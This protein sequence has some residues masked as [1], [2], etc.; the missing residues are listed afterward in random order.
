MVKTLPEITKKYYQRLTRHRSCNGNPAASQMKTDR[1]LSTGQ[2]LVRETLRSLAIKVS[3]ATVMGIVLFGSNL[4]AQPGTD[5]TLTRSFQV[6]HRGEQSRFTLFHSDGWTEVVDKDETSTLLMHA[7][8]LDVLA[9]GARNATASTL[10]IQTEKRLSEDE[11]ISRLQA[12]ASAGENATY[13]S[14]DGWPAFERYEEMLPDK[15]G[16]EDRASGQIPVLRRITIAI[17]AGSYIIRFEGKNLAPA[18]SSKD[19]EGDDPYAEMRTM[20]QNV[21]FKNH[22]NPASTELL[23]EEL[24]EQAQLMRSR[25]LEE[26][27][28]QSHAA[29]PQHAP[30]L[31]GELSDLGLV[32]NTENFSEIEVVAS[33]DGQNIIV[34]TNSRRYSVSNDGGQTFTQDSISVL[35]GDVAYGA[36]GD[37]SLAYGQSGDFYF[38]FIAYPN[39]AGGAGNGTAGCTTG[40][41]RSTND[42]QDFSHRGHATFCVFNDPDGGGP[43]T[44][45]FPDQE[46]IAADRANP[47]GTGQDQVYSAWRNFTPA[48]QNL[49]CRSFGS[50]S[51]QSMLTCSTDGGQTFGI[52]RNLV[53]DFGRVTVGQDGFVYVVTRSFG[54]DPDTLDIDKYSSCQNGLVQQAGFPNTVFNASSTIDCPVPGLDRCNDGNDLRSVSVT[55][56]DLDPS[57]IFVSFA[58][59]TTTGTDAGATPSDQI[60][61]NDDIRIADSTNG[62]LNWSA[63]I[64]LN[65]GFTARR[66][67]PWPCAVG[68]TAYVGWYDRR[69][70]NATENSFTDY[71]L[72]SA[73]RSGGSLVAGAEFRVSPDSDSNCDAGWGNSAPR[74]TNDSESCTDQPQQAGFCSGAGTRCDF[75]D[76]N[77]PGGETCDTGGGAPK[78]GDYSGIACAAGRVY[79]AY[80][81]ATPPGG[82]QTTDIDSFLKT[83]LVCCVPQIQV[84]GAVNFGEACGLEGKTETLQ[85]CNT[86][87]ENL[88]VDSITSSD[89]Q[90]A[91]TT[92]SSGYPV[93]ISAGAC[94]PFEVTYDPDGIGDDSGVLTIINNDPVN[95]ALEVPVTGT[96]GEASINTFIV[97]SG[98]FGNVCT[99]DIHDLNLTIQS[100]GSCDL[101]IDSVSLSGTDAADFELPD[102]S[103]AGTIIE[104]GNS[105]LVPV[106]FAPDNFTDPNPRTASVDVASST[107]DGDSLPLDQTPIEGTVPPPDI[108]LAIANMGNF[109]NVC[110]GDFADLDLTLFNQGMCD[111]EISNIELVPPGGSF[112]LP[113]DLDLPLTLSPDADFT[114]PVRYAPDMCDDDP[115]N[116]QIKITSD[117][118]DEGMKF[119]DIS[120]TSPCPNLVI[121][122]SGLTGD[123]AFPATVTDLDGSLGCY[124]EKITVLRNNS[125]CL[126]TITSITASAVDEFTVQTPSEFPVFLPGGE[127]TLEVTVRFTPQSLGDPL[128]PDEFTG[129]L[130]IVS[131]DPDGDGLAGLC[132]EGVAQS[133]VRVLATDISSGFP[134]VVDEVDNIT[135]RSKGKKT[136]SPI[137]LKFTDVTPQSVDI[138]ENTVTW[139]VDQETLPSAQTE[140]NNPKSSYQVSAKEGNLQ[141]AQNFNLGQCNFLEFQLQLQ[142]SDS[143]ICLLLPKGASC[144][145]AGECCSGKCKGPNGN[146]TCK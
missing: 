1:D 99:D 117:D 92:P 26:P 33:P 130:T 71:Y 4:A 80:A 113:S 19:P 56:D 108:N 45:C 55:V 68:G 48:G 59:H 43:L 8:E 72:G 78:Y 143:E 2:V 75:S 28:S 87:V 134:L 73:K 124:S 69:G 109:G 79:A 122:P 137:N 111:L 20:A 129:V 41:T 22:G 6:Q 144:T 12:L 107:Q 39:G 37:P 38:A 83:D 70:A 98:D 54:G 46:H 125:M 128:A 13:F 97:D 10:L 66:Y 21:L 123:F 32:I 29:P 88:E 40:I 103:L 23:L 135:I 131:D 63:P 60:V 104:A 58:E 44:T 24:R 64:N 105:L 16:E 18:K 90:F 119:V 49:N 133:G 15:I 102:G 52:T 50:G 91:V 51:V 25:E 127:E 3:F 65:P 47:S 84:P 31:P 82:P 36:N 5:P 121:D 35:G 74:S 132:G 101:E 9:T 62:G 141:D 106:R 146:K 140:G 85:V 118:P 95:P 138:C 30:L 112:I 81:S 89:P 27:D 115:E 86:G 116:A 110:K 145:N 136:P 100:N 114:Y 142:D 126:L 34:A 94:F 57:H 7:S 120:G 61:E 93:V 96:V 53:G 67:M 14:I 77:C 139:H 17:A 11:A 76:V 42:G